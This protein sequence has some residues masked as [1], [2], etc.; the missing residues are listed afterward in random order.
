VNAA[1]LL[2]ADRARCVRDI[3]RL[4]KMRVQALRL[5]QSDG[6]VIEVLE[7]INRDLATERRELEAHEC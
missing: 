1:N 4:E 7:S 6:E 2:A 3:A 5:P